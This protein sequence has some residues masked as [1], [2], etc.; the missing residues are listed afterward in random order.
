MEQKNKKKVSENT[1]LKKDVLEYLSK[2]P[3]FINNNIDLLNKMFALSKKDENILLKD[4][5]KEI[6]KTAKD[7]KEIQEKLS[8]FSNEVISFRKVD[9]LINYIEEFID[10]EFPSI[11]INFN[12]IKL[13]GFNDLGTKYFSSNKDLINT[14]FL[15]KTPILL[16][17]AEIKLYSLEKF[18]NNKN[19]ALV[20]CPLGIEYP[21][22]I[23]FVTYKSEMMGLN[24]QFDLLSSLTETISY[25]LEQ[26][27]QR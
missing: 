9:L 23:I 18:I 21:V 14:I 19:E 27:I 24:L 6:V 2:N 3:E 10:R 17:K 15:K 8:K 1:L 5:L 4:K 20:V 11:K 26:Y 25:S 16:T 13:N 12:L 22:G 7:N